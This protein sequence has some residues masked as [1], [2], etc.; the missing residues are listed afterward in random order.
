MSTPMNE[1]NAPVDTL[2]VNANIAT[3]EPNSTSPLGIERNVALCVKAGKIAAIIRQDKVQPKASKIIDLKGQWVLPGF[4]DCHTHLVY[5]GHRAD[6]YA[7]RAAGA[8]YEEIANAGGGIISTMQKTRTADHDM[9]FEASIKRARC[10][11]REG[12]THLEI[13]SGYG[14][15]LN[16]ER[17]QL[18][19]ARRIGRELKVGVT[20]TLLA[21]H[22]TPPEYTGDSDAY[23]K[24]VIE[25]ILPTL[26]KENLIDAVDMFCESI[27]FSRQQCQQLILAC[28]QYA[29]PFKVHTDQ[30][31][32]SGLT[33][34]A[35]HHN[36]LSIEHAEQLTDIDIE[37]LSGSNTVV[38]LLPGA[39]YTLKDTCKPPVE[40]LRAAGVNMAVATDLN[41]GSSPIASILLAGNM[42][43][44]LFGLSCEEAL[45]GMT[46]KASLALGMNNKIG[47]IVTG[48]DASFSIWDIDNPTQMLYEVNQHLPTEIYIQGALCEHI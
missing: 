1:N 37:A 25:H 31:H 28:H 41:P 21:A 7:L 11:I 20:T 44:T 9:L 40:A 30:I 16:N 13:K 18:E 8:S 5:G 22:T 29:L 15:D 45:L 32:S 2:F 23:L 19:V 27:A 6:E 47:R 3:M 34:F 17:K 36:A 42:A 4:I 35:V 38:V 14:L 48:L 12:V 26:F 24:L 33:P 39:Y 10:L 43:V 46:S